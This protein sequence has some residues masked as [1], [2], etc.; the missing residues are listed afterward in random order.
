[1]AKTK[2]T[3]KKHVKMSIVNLHAAGYKNNEI[4]IKERVNNNLLLSGRLL[5]AQT[6]IF[7]CA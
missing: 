1:M 5:F 4:L 7:L 3:G 6:T 2:I